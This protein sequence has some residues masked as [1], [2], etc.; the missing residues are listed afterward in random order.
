MMLDSPVSFF[1]LEIPY[2]KALKE[3]LTFCHLFIIMN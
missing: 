1:C 2:Q 3:G